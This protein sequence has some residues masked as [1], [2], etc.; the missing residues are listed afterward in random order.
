MGDPV[1]ASLAVMAITGAASAGATAYSAHEQRKEARRAER[2]QE[3][4]LKAQEEE[5]RKRGPEATVINEEDTS[6]E[7]ARKRL[8]RRGFLGT[9]RTG[10]TGL[11]T[12]ADTAGTG[13]KGTLG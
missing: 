9:L 8:L 7:D 6:I 13:L 11:G 3:K 12:A 10:E 2:A 4:A 1:T 5:A